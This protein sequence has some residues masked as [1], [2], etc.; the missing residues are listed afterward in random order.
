MMLLVFS[1]LGWDDDDDE[2][3][4][5]VESSG[6]VCMKKVASSFIKRE[7]DKRRETRNESFLAVSEE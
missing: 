2:D 3:K 6:R 7:G 5:D 1:C 4:D